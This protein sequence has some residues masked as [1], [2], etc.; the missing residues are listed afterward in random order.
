MYTELPK[1]TSNTGDKKHIKN[2]F[3]SPVIDFFM[4]FFMPMFDLN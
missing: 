1:L 3:D 4:C 2:R